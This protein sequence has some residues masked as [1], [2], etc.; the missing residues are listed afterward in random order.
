[1]SIARFVGGMVRGKLIS[2]PNWQGQAS[3]RGWAI[4]RRLDSRGSLV[5]LPTT[6]ISSP[7][8]E[9]L[10]E[11]AA[12]S[13]R[14]RPVSPTPDATRPPRTLQSPQTA[15]PATTTTMTMT[16]VIAVTITDRPGNS[17]SSNSRSTQSIDIALRPADPALD[18]ASGR[19]ADSGGATAPPPQPPVP[20]ATGS[21]TTRPRTQ[22]PPQTRDED[23]GGGTSS[24]SAA[25]CVIGM[26]PRLEMRLA[27]NR[28]I[29]N[30]EDLVNYGNG[31]DLA[32]ILGHDLSSF[33]RRTGREMLSRCPPPRS[34]GITTTHSTTGTCQG[35]GSSSTSPQLLLLRQQENNSKMDTPTPSRRKATSPSTW[36]SFASADR[37]DADSD[38]GEQRQQDNLSDLERL[39]REEKK[40][41]HQ[42]RNGQRQSQQ[43]VTSSHSTPKRK[44]TRTL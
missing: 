3:E 13:Q 10:L 32:T 12:E 18:D 31:L 35:P 29:M 14:A 23:V 5:P 25:A 20:A 9:I 38:A 43:T 30:D 16:E 15:A 41:A 34:S 40:V 1:M 42:L 36:S 22:L 28:D 19:A 8:R 11:A 37:A 21:V 24:G 27:L 39:A 4:G 6:A 33:Q 7:P 26:S 44:T 2:G 17:S